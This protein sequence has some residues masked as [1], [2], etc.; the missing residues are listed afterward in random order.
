MEGDDGEPSLS[1]AEWVEFFVL[2]EEGK[3]AMRS[4]EVGGGRRG[5]HS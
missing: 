4:A 3:E 5:E 1:Q 2:C